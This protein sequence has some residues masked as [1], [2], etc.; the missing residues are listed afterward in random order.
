MGSWIAKLAGHKKDT[1][2]SLKD[3]HA[4]AAYTLFFGCVAFVL[5]LWI[6]IAILTTIRI[7]KKYS[8]RSEDGDTKTTFDLQMGKK[9]LQTTLDLQVRKKL[10]QTLRLRQSYQQAKLETVE[11]IATP[12][13]AT[14]G[15]NNNKLGIQLVD[16]PETDD[17]ADY[18]G[19]YVA[20][21]KPGSLAEGK[22]FPGDKILAIN[23]F[24]LGKA[25]LKYASEVMHALRQ[26]EGH[27][28]FSVKRA[29][30][31]E[32]R[33][34][35]AFSMYCDDED[36]GKKV[37]FNKDHMEVFEEAFSMFDVHA[38]GKIQFKFLFP[39]LRNLGYNVH[40]AEA[41][42]Y[43]NE[44]ELAD[45]QT[46]TFGEVI[47]FL[48]E[49][50]AEQHE[51]TEVTCV[52]NVFDPDQT[53]HVS[54]IEIQEALHVWYGDRISEEEVQEISAFADLDNNGFVKEQDFERLL[55]PSLTL[56]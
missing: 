2:E 5:L 40:K 52:Y 21:I 38:T 50:V 36:T 13:S 23:D 17:K 30:I 44:L 26:A 8:R 45:K 35:E 16:E 29:Q 15:E 22:L 42:D 24:Y 53:G 34:N 10:V 19:I 28:K 55:L 7:Y 56:Y 49:I 33:V 46:V 18:P 20:D 32:Q 9:L 3:P 12:G 41:W 39:L 37:A 25:S 14:S 54:V 27:L 1:A 4:I 48:E 43:L 11:I 31:R 51:K 6:V 47:K